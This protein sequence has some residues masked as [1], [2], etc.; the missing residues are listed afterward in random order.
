MNASIA[1]NLGGYTL[2][3]AR[4]YG[5]LSEE[6]IAALG[7]RYPRVTDPE[8][9]QVGDNVIIWWSG[10]NGPHRYLLTKHREATPRTC[11]LLAIRFVGAKTPHTQVWRDLDNTLIEPLP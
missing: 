7:S 9:L 3:D 1:E 10:G 8:S 4:R 2:A 11:P 6:D 5:T